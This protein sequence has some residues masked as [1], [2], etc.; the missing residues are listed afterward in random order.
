MLQKPVLTRLPPRPRKCLRKDI[1]GVCIP[2]RK[3]SLIKPRSVSA[4][5]G[6]RSHVPRPVQPRP[7]PSVPEEDEKGDKP[8]GSK[9]KIEEG[10]EKAEETERDRIENRAQ[11]IRPEAGIEPEIELS[12]LRQRDRIVPRVPVVLKE[13]PSLPGGYTQKMNDERALI[14]AA[15]S[16]QK[17]KSVTN[18]QKSLSVLTEGRVTIEPKNSNSELGVLV[19]KHGPSGERMH[20]LANDGPALDGESAS[21]YA[22]TELHDKSIKRVQST[23]DEI[24]SASEFAQ[25][26]GKKALGSHHEYKAQVERAMDKRQRLR[27]E[28]AK[29]NKFFDPESDNYVDAFVSKD[30]ALYD[31]LDLARRALPDRKAVKGRTVRRRDEEAK[32]SKESKFDS[33]E[34]M[35]PRLTRL[36]D[37]RIQEAETALAD[38]E[39]PQY[40]MEERPSLYTGARPG[41]Q[42]GFRKRLD[43]PADFVAERE[44]LREA[45]MER[46]RQTEGSERVLDMFETM[47]PEG[48]PKPAPARPKPARI[49]GYDAH[50]D[51]ED[52]FN[53]NG[54]LHAVAHENVGNHD[55][56]VV[57]TENHIPSAPFGLRRAN[58]IQQR[59][60]QKAFQATDP[61]S[62]RELLYQGKEAFEAAPKVFG[63]RMA[64]SATDTRNERTFTQEVQDRILGRYNRAKGILSGDIN[65]LKLLQDVRDPAKALRQIT[66][67]DLNVNV[68]T[69][70]RN[71]ADITPMKAI[72]EL[73]PAQR[74]NAL[75]KITLGKKLARD[76]IHDNIIE[77]VE[78]GKSFT[79]YYREKVGHPDDEPLNILEMPP[80]EGRARGK[81]QNERFQRK[82]MKDWSNKN[83]DKEFLDYVLANEN[84][85]ARPVDSDAWRGEENSF[86]ELW[87]SRNSVEEFAPGNV[88]LHAR[89]W[90]ETHQSQSAVPKGRLNSYTGQQEL[91]D[92]SADETK[93]A[94]V[95]MQDLGETKTGGP[96]GKGFTDTELNLIRSADPDTFNPNDDVLRVRNDSKALADHLRS[97]RNA[98]DGKDQPSRMR[99]IR[100]REARDR[101]ASQTAEERQSEMQQDLN[102]LSDTSGSQANAKA[103]V[104]QVGKSVLGAFH[105]TE[106]GSGIAGGIAGDTA[107]NI[108][109]GDPEDEGDSTRSNIGRYGGRQFVSGGVSGGVQH[110]VKAGMG[111][112]GY[113]TTENLQGFIEKGAERLAKQTG[114]TAEEVAEKVGRESLLK[115]GARSALGAGELGAAMGG[116]VVGA[117]AG[118]LATVGT[119]AAIE[120]SKKSG[121]AEAA[122]ITGGTVFAGPLGGVATAAALEFG[123]KHKEITEA[124]VGGAA[125]GASAALA[126][127]YLG[128]AALSEIGPLG[129]IAGGAV[130]G[131]MGLIGYGLE[132]AHAKKHLKDIFNP[133]NIAGGVTDIADLFFGQQSMP[134]TYAPSS[135]SY[136]TSNI[137]G[138]G[139]YR[140]AYVNPKTGIQ[141]LPIAAK[142][143]ETNRQA[144]INRSAESLHHGNILERTSADIGDFIS[145]IFS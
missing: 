86:R 67:D 31:H 134:K 52:I 111:A 108:I 122:L 6:R 101:F 8:G 129:I 140:Q 137:H 126:G 42:T 107:S 81:L 105:W 58:D 132:K 98:F 22:F 104:K 56:H 138:D 79:E 2:D 95:E 100:P 135:Y 82:F 27:Y 62:I 60:L 71:A 11:E 1:F 28:H 75:N 35:P 106:I 89:L 5:H 121:A 115:S 15:N 102:V 14:E 41:K 32:E 68:D 113:G 78:D 130:G 38:Y 124:A 19:A 90:D 125:G 29:K 76:E 116:G 72:H 109:F 87:N 119:D 54:T 114:A 57:R 65:A 83:P 45:V 85:K 136:Y 21:A 20:A 39:R 144:I 36:E 53:S 141:A 18:A 97:T 128:G 120:A 70:P 142:P 30:R 77:A 50:A 110:V 88:A 46:Q 23:L 69:V 4:R 91:F 16:I 73:S 34:D 9:Q 66:R 40:V 131:A 127:A 92:V 13:K 94:D 25:H 17:G 112:A 3:T 33:P 63:E 47:F 74:N 43:R 139:M 143:G 55:V 26:L 59:L 61:L 84:T 133:V 12:S 49:R 64:R 99:D 93:S 7:R 24:H 48:R 37:Q 103:T 44:R 96:Q 80:D 145:G 51:T 10:L 117:V 118:T 123:K